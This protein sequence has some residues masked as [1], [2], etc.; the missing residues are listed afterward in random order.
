M[1][2]YSIDLSERDI[3]L[4]RVA[5]DDFCFTYPN[6]ERSIGME[7]ILQRLKDEVE[8]TDYSNIGV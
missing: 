1:N 5:L 8:D 6:T 2:I 4:I 7:Y 3:E